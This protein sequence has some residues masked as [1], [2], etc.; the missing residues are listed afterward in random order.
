MESFASRPEPA[1][2]GALQPVRAAVA[3]VLGPIRTFVV[4][5]LVLVPMHVVALTGLLFATATLLTRAMPESLL[6][7]LGTW[8]LNLVVVVVGL[9]SGI[10]AG[11]ASAARRAT[12]R[13]ES[14][15][16][17]AV[18]GM[19]TAAGERRIPA[20]PLDEA[21][22]RYEAIL[23]R[24]V[25]LMFERLQ[26]PQFVHRLARR[27]L[28]QAPIDDFLADC[29]AR[30][31]SQVGFAEVRNWSIATGIPIAL[32][33]IRRQASIARAIGLGIPAIAALLLF[34]IR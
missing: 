20:L 24:I 21:R 28:R 6:G 5:A 16:R 22:R 2:P 7:S 15:I 14:T 4:G 18:L 12:D 30:G 1:P 33:P 26:V 29:E 25:A 19:D 13:L 32:A 9:L 31:L 17:D 3:G 27:G 8:S 10:V 11:L 23:D 34:L